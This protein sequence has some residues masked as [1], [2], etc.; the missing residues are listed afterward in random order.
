MNY[1]A[2]VASELLTGGDALAPEELG[3]CVAGLRQGF[4]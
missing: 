1:S 2:G 4:D 3:V